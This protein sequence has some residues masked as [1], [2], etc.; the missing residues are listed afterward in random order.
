[1]K[2]PLLQSSGT[3][4]PG[5]KPN[6]TNVGGQAVI[7]G[8][9]MRAPGA[10]SIVCRRQD[11]SLVLRERTVPAAPPGLFRLPFF[12]G[13]H[14]LVSSLRI[15]HQALRWS[16]EILE[17]DLA[18]QEAAEKAGAAK[19]V[20][21]G[22]ASVA[23][24]AL[25]SF[26]LSSPEQEPESE[27]K[28]ASSKPQAVPA[29]EPKS[30]S[31]LLMALPML[32]AIGLFIALPQLAAEGINAWLKLGLEVTSPG[33]QAITGGSKL[34]IVISYLAGIRMIPEVRR[35]F[36]YHGA[37]HKSI[38]T[39]EAKRDLIVA[40]ARPTSALHARCGTTF[41]IMVAFVSVFVFSA[42]GAFLPPL[43]GGRLL[44][45]VG[46][47]FMKLPLLPVIAGIT[48]ELQRF[49]ARYCSTGPLQFLLWPGFLVQKITTAEPDDDQL[50][51]ALASLRSA[52]ANASVELPKDHEDR[53]FE[54]YD[55][56]ISDPA[57]RA[58]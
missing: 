23:L 20:P 18:K 5:E 14:T 15:G 19:R 12:R 40:E 28:K 56:L 43:P 22:A 34:I 26:L 55:S 2:Q 37:E 21:P 10:L 41:I 1:M 50:E 25:T 7:E 29:E 24:L 53:A 13:V 48:F 32:F 38:S 6:P 57:Y 45:S 42:V 27:P 49:F 33:F 8:V 36:Q 3:A 35:V 54:S 31:G 46:F 39:Y 58:A 4:D 17:E 52:L 30:G 51:V 11:G 47:F 16:A 9:M 44:Q